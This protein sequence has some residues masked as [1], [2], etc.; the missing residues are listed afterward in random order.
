MA[1]ATRRKS[2]AHNI[3]VPKPRLTPEGL[4]KS[5]IALRPL[6]RQ[7]QAETEAARR[8]LDEVHDRCAEA[9]FYRMMQPRRFGGY[10]FDL[11]TFVRV[12][13]ELARGCPSTAWSVVF[14]SGHPH[15][16][17]GFGLRA[18]IEAYG[19]AGDFRAPLVAGAQARARKVEGGYVIAGAWDYASGIDVATHFLAMTPVRD[20]LEDPPQG[21]IFALVNRDQ[22]EI[23]HNWEMLGMQGSGSHR[24]LVEEQFIPEHRI[25]PRDVLAPTVRKPA[26]R[27][28]ANPMY[29]G[30]SVNVLM[31]EIAAVAIGTGYAAL[32]AYEEILK[33]RTSP[34]SNAIRAENR[35][36]QV[37]FG[38]AM[39][40]LDTARAALLGCAQEFMD[41]CAA[42]VA[43][44][45]PFTREKS[46]R[47]AQ[48]EQQCCRLAGDAVS[49]MFRNAGTSQIKPG[50]PM[51]RYWRDISTLLT[52]VTLAYDRNAE[53]ATKLHFGLEVQP[54]LANR[55]TPPARD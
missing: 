6:L 10:E 52:H 13:M 8:I 9:G 35:E 50:M 18:Q 24:V 34:M 32:D 33:R 42:E 30:P 29:A 23:E 1:T 15:V 47:M 25:S 20:S 7:R 45:A 27:H 43:G 17:A 36:F 31:S 51:E 44:K 41:S 38:E 5:A 11:P 53:Q 39:A 4:I 28:F 37:Y 46:A 48:V 14:T 26:E 40:I 3:P 55:Q 2:R 22:Y 49:L 54:P 12:A 21:A 16:F 19:S